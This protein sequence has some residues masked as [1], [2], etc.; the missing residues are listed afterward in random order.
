M[1]QTRR[2]ADDFVQEMPEASYD[3]VQRFLGPP[4]ELAQSFLE[5]IEPSHLLQFQKRQRIFR[6]GLLTLLAAVLLLVT[7]FYIR[8]LHTPAEVFVTETL[9][10]YDETE[11][12]T[13]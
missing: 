1:A 8:L 9:I 4:Q 10:I 2:M 11:D 3:E 5:T 7:A 6:R 13:K 12:E